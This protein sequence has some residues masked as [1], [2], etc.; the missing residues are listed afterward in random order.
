MKYLLLCLSLV[1]GLT[2]CNS[3]Q[4]TKTE[5]E[6][7]PNIYSTPDD[8]TEMNEA[9][10]NAQKSLK[11]F[12]TAFESNKYDTSTFALKVKFPTKTGA[13]HI[14]ATSITIQNGEYFG[15][16]DNLP[17]LTTQ[18]KYGDKIKL[19]KA[20]I[21]DWMFSDNGILQGGYTIKLIRSRMT[22]EERN[23]FDAEF[24]FKIE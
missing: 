14:W 4:M 1:V 2:S 15:V 23:N 10:S 8:D 24:S 20:D 9:V 12:D 17:D 13:E 16:V 19:T 22:K 7:E 11:R 6:G 5:R 18:V 21:T 3:D